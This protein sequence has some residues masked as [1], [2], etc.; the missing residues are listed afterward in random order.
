MKNP[1]I[2]YVCSTST[3][4]QR[5]TV[6]I[7]GFNNYVTHMEPDL[8]IDGN[9]LYTISS[10]GVLTTD[11]ITSTLI[12]GH[13]FRNSYHEGVGSLARFGWVSGFRQISPTR[14]VIAD[15]WNGCLRHLDR[16]SLETSQYAGMCGQR[17]YE[18]GNTNARF[19]SPH[20]VIDDVKLADTLIVSD[21]GN[22]ALRHVYTYIDMGTP[23]PVANLMESSDRSFRPLGMTQDISGDIYLTSK[24]QH[25]IFQLIYSSKTLSV[26]AGSTTIG[27]V[28]SDF[29]GSRFAEPQEILVIDHGR[30]LLVAGFMDGMVRVLDL[31]T[32]ETTSLCS[33]DFGQ[34]YSNTSTCPLQE[35]SSLMVLNKTLYV[36]GSG[37]IQ[38]IKG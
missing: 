5:A 8:H 36:G 37:S 25:A 15:N 21:A 28:D 14:V 9:I 20:S 29:S 38:K 1:A 16:L 4:F 35:P 13:S 34:N 11:G 17:G 32:M 22:C 18:E 31:V 30:K 3:N 6:F 26:L 27:Y 2:F 7:D 19:Q 23:S 33:G 24:Y 10:G 12:A